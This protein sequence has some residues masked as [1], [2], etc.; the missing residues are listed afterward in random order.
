MNEQIRETNLAWGKSS[1]LA[2]SPA[3]SLATVTMTTKGALYPGAY[4]LYC[5]YTQIF[6][7]C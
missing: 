3:F 1:G 4:T 5:L 6:L 7:P 2:L